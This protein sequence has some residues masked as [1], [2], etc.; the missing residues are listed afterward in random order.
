MVASPAVRVGTWTEP[1]PAGMSWI[2]RLTSEPW[3]LISTGL[4][5]AAFCTL[6]ELAVVAALPVLSSS[7][8]MLPPPELCTCSWFG[9]LMIPAEPSAARTDWPALES[10]VHPPAS[11]IP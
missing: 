10:A 7:W 6:S 9:T 8:K 11:V 1:L 4:P 3:V 5:V 2:E